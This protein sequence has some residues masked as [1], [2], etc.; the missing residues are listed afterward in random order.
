MVTICL[1]GLEGKI[2]DST[3]RN[4]SF[5]ILRNILGAGDPRSVVRQALYQGPV[6]LSFVYNDIWSKLLK[7]SMTPGHPG[8]LI[9][10]NLFD[11]KFLRK[12]P[13]IALSVST[14]S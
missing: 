5:Q 3:I 12:Q 14:R 10:L 13:R 4:P 9:L 11:R 7:W 1:V 8:F 6:R 2:L